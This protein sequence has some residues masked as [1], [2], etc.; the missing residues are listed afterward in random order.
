MKVNTLSNMKDLLVQPKVSSNLAGSSSITLIDNLLAR[1]DQEGVLYCHWKSKPLEGELDVDFLVSND[2][3]N[4]ATGVLMQLEF[5]AATPRW[6]NN[7]PGVFHYYGYDASQDK[8]VHLHMFTRVISG[9]SLVKSHLFPF[10]EMLLKDTRSIGRLVVTSKEAEFVLFILKTFI[11][12]GSVLD[13]QREI[14]RDE[15]NREEL[16]NL[17]ASSDTTK[18]L[19]YLSD[20]CPVL[21]GKVFLECINAI[22][23]GDWYPRKWVLAQK[24]RW[25]LRIYRLHTDIGRW[26][27]YAGFLRAACLK[28]LKNQKGNKIFLNGGAVIAIVGAD[29]TGKSTLIKATSGWLRKNF[30]V[31][32]IHA[33]KPPSAWLTFPINLILRLNRS[34]KSNLRIVYNLGNE[35]SKKST[36][37]HA[38]MKDQDSLIYAI[39]AVCLAWDRRTLLLKARRAAA[40]GEMIVCDRY[41]SFAAGMMDSPRL[42]EDN[43]KKSFTKSLYN[44]LARL[45]EKIYRQIA[46]P[47][48]V[49]RLKVSLETAMKRNAAREIIDD[50][51]Y[52][53][54]RH[55]QA[56]DWY[57]PGTR[58]IADI[59]TDRTLED[60]IAEVK[61][62]IWSS[63]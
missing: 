32:T 3:L 48:I 11:R 47:D 18:V 60:T 7:Y 14:R 45:E 35:R 30:V 49:L 40:N 52:L 42:V 54:N 29:A 63:L 44:R 21:D 23:A 24:I 31:Y 46:P 61:H 8:T 19:D 26:I 50:E 34:I 4:R 17:K 41:P 20:Y 6:G 53:Q 2:S 15:I 16:R 25:Q 62:V 1:F 43:T 39:R 37:I 58:R 56:V 38:E 59:N 13:F 10:A 12:Y 9:E 22:E 55:Q 27:D 5:K 57:I 28:K 33:G 51:I 36:S